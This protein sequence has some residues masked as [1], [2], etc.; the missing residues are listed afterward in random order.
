MKRVHIVSKPADTFALC[1]QYIDYNSKR[2]GSGHGWSLIEAIEEYPSFYHSE[3]WYWCQECSEHPDMAL[4]V[5]A[6][7]GE[8]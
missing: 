2:M 3:P 4:Y 6:H 5:L 1:G 8:A 7:A